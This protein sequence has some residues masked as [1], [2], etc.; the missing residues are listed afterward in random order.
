MKKQKFSKHM[1]VHYFLAAGVFGVMF[2]LTKSLFWSVLALFINIFLDADHLVD[3]WLA[4]GF[5]LDYRRFVRETRGGGLYFVK[6]QKGI[7]PLHSWELLLLFFVVA[8]VLNLPQLAIAIAFGF[9]P[10]LL[11]DQITYAQRPLMYSL[12]FR[13]FNKFDFKE[14]CGRY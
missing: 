3:Y 8:E 6:S 11:W 10:H 14:I 13:A 1:L 9:L 7:V 2:F 4:N 12:I 5:N